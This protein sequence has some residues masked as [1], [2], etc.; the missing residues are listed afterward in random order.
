MP[1]R[2]YVLGD[3]AEVA[4]YRSTVAVPMLRDGVPNGTINVARTQAGP[5]TNRQIDLLKTFAD[6]AVIAIE[7]VRLFQEL[8]ARNGEL[9]ATL[10]QQTATSEILRVISSSPTDVQPVFDAIAAAATT[11]CGAENA[12]VFLF[13]GVLIHFAAHHR[14]TSEDLEAL[15]R[16]FPATARTRQCYRPCDPHA[17]GRSYGHRERSRIPGGQPGCCGL[18]GGPVSA[19]APRRRPDRRYQCHPTRAGALLRCPDR[20]ATDVR[21]PGRHRHRERPAVQGT[22]VA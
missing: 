11:L 1:I 13:D 17:R 12:G 20:A 5:F 14:R 4:T 21:R 8:E 3:V 10:E 9:T 6:Q 18:P 19:D 16:T 2:N 15:R 22:G 7:N